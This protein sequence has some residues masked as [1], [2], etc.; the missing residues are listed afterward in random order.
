MI[1]IAFF[2]S[3]LFDE[4]VISSAYLVYDTFL[5]YFFSKFII[6]LSIHIKAKFA[7]NGD[8]GAH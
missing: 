3:F 6:I 7:K 4:N 5:S 2:I 8:V 1:R